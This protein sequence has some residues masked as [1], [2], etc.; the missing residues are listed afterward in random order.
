VHI[1]RQ[2]IFENDDFQFSLENINNLPFVH[3]YCKRFDRSVLEEIK[4]R[5]GEL[6]ISLYFD[7]YEEL[8]TYTKDMRIPNLVGGGEVVGEHE[9]NKVIRWELK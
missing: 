7:G 9:G 4:L 8:F 1:R 3:L 5:W 6:L 2:L